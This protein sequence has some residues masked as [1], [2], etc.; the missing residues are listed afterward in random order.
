MKKSDLKQLIKPLVKECIHEVLLEEGLL[1]NVVAEV[2][3]G[4]QGNLVVEARNPDPQPERIFN[5]NLQME[6]KTS[7]TRQ[8][9][10]E[11]RK[12]LLDAVGKD[13][14]NGVNL[15]ENTAPLKQASNPTGGPEMPPVLGDDPGNS[16]VDISSI[17]GNA[18]QIWQAMK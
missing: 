18:S 3:K 11:H 5:E 16:G 4:M 6:R 9:L 17:M 12:K 8:K 7:E 1:S 10:K 13:A 2:A 15:F 14:Y